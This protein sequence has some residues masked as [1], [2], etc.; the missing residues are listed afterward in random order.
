[1]ENKKTRILYLFDKKYW[2]NRMDRNRFHSIDAISKHKNVELIKNGPGWSDFENAKQIVDK[3]NPDLIIWYK[4]LDIV[5]FENIENIPKC[6]RYN[7]MYDIEWTTKE[8]VESGSSLIICH[9]ENDIKNYKHLKNVKFYH[10]PHCSEENIFK[11]YNEEKLYDVLLVGNLDPFFYPLRSRFKKLLNQLEIAGIKTKIL[12]H[13][14]YTITDVEEQ[15][16]NFA[17]EINRSKI[18][19]TCSSR[20]KYALSKYSEIPLCGSLLIADIPDEDVD[21]YK[22]W[23]V[24]INDKMSD[25]EIVDIIKHYINHDEEREKKIKKSIELN[26][27]SR[28]QKHYAEKFVNI[29]HEY[30]E[31]ESIK[32]N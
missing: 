14:G 13:P 4:P 20:F 15:T 8:I 26:L 22:Q 7:E 17:K 19:I 9:H 30:L 21:W 25:L 18:T 27:Q 29:F 6:L 28:T 23:I 11:N 24:E 2:E 12:K 1:M 10:N 5:G 31:S 3:Y 32:T 16:I